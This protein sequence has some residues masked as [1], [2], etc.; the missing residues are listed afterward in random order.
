MTA[1]IGKEKKSRAS[2]ACN[3]CRRRK[4][5]CDASSPSCGNCAKLGEI[6]TYR[7][8]PRNSAE[9]VYNQ[10]EQR[11][12]KVESMLVKVLDRDREAD[13]MFCENR[14]SR[15]A[16]EPQAGEPTSLGRTS[17]YQSTNTA[18]G[19]LEIHQFN[20]RI[21]CFKTSTTGDFQNGFLY[22]S[23][24]FL[25]LLSPSELERLSQR[26]TDPNICLRL[27]A[28]T[29][30]VWRKSLAIIPE[31]S[32]T[33]IGIF[34]DPTL[35]N[36]CKSIYFET[37]GNF[38]HTLLAPSEV[39]VD[40]S[41]VLHPYQ[42]GITAAI[43]ILGVNA[44]KLRHLQSKY[45]SFLEP[46]LKAAC[47]EAIKCLNLLRFSRPGFFEVRL[48]ILLL[49]LLYEFTNL[50]SLLQYARPIV[51][52]SRAIGLDCLGE[53]SNYPATEAGRREYV[54]LIAVSMQ[55]SFCVCL[56]QKPLLSQE[57]VN[58]S[59]YR[60]LP[61]SILQYFEYAIRLNIIFDR[62][63]EIL[64]FDCVRDSQIRD[65]AK[66]IDE[67]DNELSDWL[68]NTPED[69][70]NSPVLDRKNLCDFISVFPWMDLRVQYFHTYIAIHA[71]PAFN[72]NIFP[73]R[74]AD[75]LQ[76]VMGAS[77]LLFNVCK[78]FTP[79]FDQLNINSCCAISTMIC[80]LLYRRIHC[81]ELSS[82]FEEEKNLE[83][84]MDNFLNESFLEELNLPV[85][86]IW[87]V[88]AEIITHLHD[89]PQVNTS[90]PWISEFKDNISE[91]A[92][93][94]DQCIVS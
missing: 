34:P 38:I 69:L 60:F 73:M 86:K 47:Y 33:P 28:L 68:A 26:V 11:L 36:T 75:S 45:E 39:G 74:H 31:I 85:M 84:C 44:I 51:E 67:L 55:R 27:E 57:Y 12:E 35:F 92:H 17:E 16:G 53:N 66:K 71:L 64:F 21:S 37:K 20:Q 56:S 65:V 22:M 24:I 93:D 2:I 61:R 8:H 30:D 4:A 13:R 50:P 58:L 91:L 46:Q 29:Q 89:V 48:S 76:K 6:C 25:T 59:S 7:Q 23:N 18:S 81:S 77:G 43:T 63:Y 10:F 41:L 49:W 80:V 32:V 9:A 40:N 15:E 1:G 19:S 5:R 3:N 14:T 42:R 52:M 90:E 62:A 87:K 83:R 94:E 78:E 88:M 72:Q 54:W 70:L 79:N 82:L